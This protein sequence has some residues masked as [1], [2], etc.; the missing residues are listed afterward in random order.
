MGVLAQIF[1]LLT[2]VSF[3]NKSFNLALLPTKKVMVAVLYVRATFLFVIQLVI[4]IIII[5]SY[6]IGLQIP[7]IIIII[8][9]KSRSGEA[10]FTVILLFLLVLAQKFMFKNQKFSVFKG[11]QIIKI[12]CSLLL[13]K[14]KSL[15]ICQKSKVQTPFAFKNSKLVNHCTKVFY[16]FIFQYISS[17]FDLIILRLSVL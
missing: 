17:V 4:T 12:V 14:C 5:Q 3:L 2:K 10:T 1:Q 15:Q 13:H 9:H 16:S 6:Q 11:K 7:N 8:I